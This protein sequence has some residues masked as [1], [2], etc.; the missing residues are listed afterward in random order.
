MIVHS[1]FPDRYFHGV[2]FCQCCA[3]G[4]YFW[5]DS[6]SV[7]LVGAMSSESEVEEYDEASTPTLSHLWQVVKDSDPHA[8]LILPDLLTNPFYLPAPKAT[9]EIK[10]AK[11]E[12]ELRR[13][14]FICDRDSKV[15]RPSNRSS[16]MASIPNYNLIGKEL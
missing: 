8:K 5:S 4:S 7:R 3:G 9:K 14:N 15:V 11:F 16:V 10:A 2:S 1:R 12:R 6:H 13:L